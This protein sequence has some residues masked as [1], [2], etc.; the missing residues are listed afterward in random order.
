M[1]MQLCA[2][3]P[4]NVNSMLLIPCL[5]RCWGKVK[6][7]K[8]EKEAACWSTR[9][10]PQGWKRLYRVV[11][12]GNHCACRT[13]RCPWK[14]VK[15]SQTHSKSCVQPAGKIAPPLSTQLYR[16]RWR[17]SPSKCKRTPSQL[18]CATPPVIATCIRFV[19]FITFAVSVT[20]HAQKERVPSL[21]AFAIMSASALPLLYP[22]SSIL[23]NTEPAVMYA[24]TMF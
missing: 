5:R 14:K 3:R 13:T 24:K 20:A 1:I 8:K 23:K 22:S 16:R 10:R 15:P 21:N 2:V 9:P 11:A 7:E 17:K 6:K 4:H 19:F 18:L 12:D